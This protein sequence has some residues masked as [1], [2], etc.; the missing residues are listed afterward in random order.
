MMSSP[1]KR[2]ITGHDAET[3][4]SIFLDHETDLSWYEIPGFGTATRSYATTQLPAILQDD[5]DVRA[6]DSQDSAASF[7]RKEFVV[8]PPEVPNVTMEGGAG[9]VNVIALDILPGSKGHMH[10]T[11]SLDISTCVEGEVHCELDSGQRV[12]LKPGVRR[13]PRTSPLKRN[14]LED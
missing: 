14:S 7:Q 2:H 11:I 5:E 9:G 8:S 6:Y 4:Q 1:V 12:L 13:V 3:G 10:R